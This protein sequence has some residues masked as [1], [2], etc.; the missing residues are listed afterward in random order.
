[1]N[2]HIPFGSLTILPHDV[3][4]PARVY[5]KSTNIVNLALR[6]HKINFRSFLFPGAPL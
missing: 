2:N 1:M 4:K 6:I 5:I 3:L